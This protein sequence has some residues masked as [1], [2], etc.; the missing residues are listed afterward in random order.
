MLGSALLK[1]ATSRLGIA[2]IVVGGLFAWHQ[3][4]KTSA[5]RKAVIGYV[6][7]VELAAAEAEAAALQEARAKLAA[8]NR[9]FAERADRAEEEAADAERRFQDYVATSPLPPGCSVPPDF[10]DLLQSN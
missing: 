3:L 8:A 2:M 6:A 1:F 4:D 5:V 9:K 7:D 10:L